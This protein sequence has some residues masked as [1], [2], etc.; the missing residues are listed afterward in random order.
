M[1][2]TCCAPPRK[3]PYELE[4]EKKLPFPEIEKRDKKK[5]SAEQQTSDL[6]LTELIGI[7]NIER[8]LE[9]DSREVADLSHRKS[10]A[11]LDTKLEFFSNNYRFWCHFEK[12]SNGNFYHNYSHQIEFPFTPEFYYLM[13]LQENLEEL[14]KKDD[15]IE[16]FEV[17]KNEITSD[18]IISASL[19]KTKKILTVAPRTFLLIRVIKRISKNQFQECQRSVDLTDLRNEETF[20]QI[21]ST[22][23]NIACIFNGTSSFIKDDSRYVLNLFTKID[24][25]STIGFNMFAI[26]IKKKFQN[27][28]NKSM[29]LM[30]EFLSK[31]HDPSTLT[32]FEGR[33]EEIAE[34]LRENL[35]ILR[36]LKPNFEFLDSNTQKLS[37]L[38]NK[39]SSL[40]SENRKSG[41]IK[42]ET[43]FMSEETQNNN[44]Q[45]SS[46]FKKSD[47]GAKINSGKN[48]ETRKDSNAKLQ[49]DF[50]N[51]E[52]NSNIAEETMITQNEESKAKIS[53]T[54]MAESDLIEKKTEINQF[55]LEKN[56]KTRMTNE[57]KD[58]Q[59][60]ATK[61]SKRNNKKDSRK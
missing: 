9:E 7:D 53:Q 19:M 47:F 24:I 61:K 26:I 34:I 3:S 23:E 59:E 1:G 49:K 52:E 54:Q 20:A 56:E 5:Q 57:E 46:G 37:S 29:K 12:Q 28:F 35:A 25:L 11:L 2:L 14:Q 15:S 32:W 31:R 21:L 60:N 44:F 41:S 58:V 22:E 51:K 8:F 10:A 43:S 36:A 40:T 6:T 27:F 18:M 50:I 33:N 42:Q 16:Y 45:T 4:M 17:L 48:S 38:Q 13:T 30:A 55:A 39:R